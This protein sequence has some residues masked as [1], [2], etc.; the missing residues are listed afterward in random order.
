M[1]KEK[2]IKDSK[3]KLELA[4]AIADNSEKVV[5]TYENIENSFFYFV[6]RIF[7]TLNKIIFDS[8]FSKLAALLIAIIIYVAVN[9][10]NNSLNVTQASQ[11]SDIPVQIIY[12]NEI[13]EISGVPNT[14]DVI[15]TGDMSDIT[16]QKTQV[17]SV[18][19]C[20]LT[21][22]TEGVHIVKLTPTNFISRLTVNVLDTPSVTVTIKKKTV[23]R[24][25]VSAEFIHTNAMSNMY[26]LGN[27]TLDQT[28]VLIRA[29]QDTIDSIAFVKALIDVSDVTETFTRTAQLAAYNQNGERVECDIFPDVVNAT[30]EVSNPSKEVPIVVRP[31]GVL[32]NNLAIDSINLDYSTV[33]IYAPENILAITDAFYVELDV[34]TIT[35]NT[36]VS[37]ALTLP[38][39]VNSISVTK[40]NMEVAV[41]QKVEKTIDGVKLMWINNT[42]NYKFSPTNA[43]DVTLSIVVTG[44]ENNVSKVTA[45][46]I[47]VNIDLNGIKPG[48]QEIDVDI[49]GTN[50]NLS[51][52]LADGRTSIEIQVV[53]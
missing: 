31:V 23:T 25:N 38:S 27:A 3:E 4:K 26:S 52:A 43:D 17:N 6:R 20:D 13:Y 49:V 14:A 40:V 21:G 37:T 41:A 42:S 5:R 12:N 53:E 2:Q 9:T 24:M 29:S 30:V 50:K 7:G 39:G 10:N 33:T 35:K 8:K 47:V 32:P 44:T 16:L 45:N 48:T 28:E 1:A 46:D 22:L 11:I 15:V 36:A 19:T 51:Y 34:S 18:L